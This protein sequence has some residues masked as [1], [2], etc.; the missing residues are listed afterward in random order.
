MEMRWNSLLVSDHTQLLSEASTIGVMKLSGE[1]SL[2][3][4]SD[5]SGNSSKLKM[6]SK[7]SMKT[8]SNTHK[9][10]L[11]LLIKQLKV[12]MNLLMNGRMLLKQSLL[13]K[14]PRTNLTW[15]ITS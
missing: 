12:L 8:M 15:Q 3:S 2:V 4:A 1:S 14:A 9:V 11:L 5:S 6:D 10:C 7:L 13:A